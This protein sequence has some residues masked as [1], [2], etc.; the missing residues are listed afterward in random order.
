MVIDQNVSFSTSSKICFVISGCI[1]I[2]GIVMS[3][4]ASKKFFRTS[5]AYLIKSDILEKNVKNK[6][7]LF[8]DLLN[9]TEENNI[10][11]IEEEN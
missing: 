1:F 3:F 11:I 8:L 9:E 10:L 6:C 5:T 2:C 7:N 4:E